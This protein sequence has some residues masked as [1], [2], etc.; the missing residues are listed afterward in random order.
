MEDTQSVSSAPQALH[1]GNM[2]LQATSFAAS[3]DQADK[4]CVQVD[5]EDLLGSSTTGSLTK[6]FTTVSLPISHPVFS[7]DAVEVLAPFSSRT[8][9]I[10]LRTLQSNDTITFFAHAFG[11]D[12]HAE[13]LEVIWQFKL[14]AQGIRSIAIDET[15]KA[16]ILTLDGTE[17]APRRIVGEYTGKEH[18]LGWKEEHFRKFFDEYICFSFMQ[19]EDCVKYH[20]P[21]NWVDLQMPKW[22]S[23]TEIS[24]VFQP[25]VSAL[26]RSL[27]EII[28]ATKESIQA[29]KTSQHGRI[30][31][32]EAGDGKLSRFI[33]S[34]SR[35]IGHHRNRS[36]KKGNL[37]LSSTKALRP[38]N[39]YSKQAWYHGRKGAH[40]RKDRDRYNQKHSVL[41][42]I[43]TQLTK[44]SQSPKSITSLRDTNALGAVI[45]KTVKPFNYISTQFQDRKPS[46]EKVP[47]AQP[48]RD[49]IAQKIEEQLLIPAQNEAILHI[50]RTVSPK[51]FDQ[52]RSG[53]LIDY[54][55]MSDGL[56]RQLGRL[57]SDSPYSTDPSPTDREQVSSFLDPEASSAQG[58]TPEMVLFTRIN[59]SK[60]P[61]ERQEELARITQR[62]VPS[63]AALPNSAC[64]G[65]QPKDLPVE[66][67]IMIWRYVEMHLPK[68]EDVDGMEIGAG[69]GMGGHG[70]TGEIREGKGAGG[71]ETLAGMNGGR[72]LVGEDDLEIDPDIDLDVDYDLEIE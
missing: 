24:A 1:N 58:L 61:A 21:A 3:V 65:L 31:A 6:R 63:L 56:Y 23:A 55:N 54:R 72:G 26:D 37:K 4:T 22:L 71:L 17:E 49:F 13:Q 34:Q 27:Q 32:N 14:F 39:I 8:G 15:A 68:E 28:S 62:T 20:I 43:N 36:S 53:R 18:Y 69:E 35:S 45:S 30:L 9:G 48:V 11:D 57:I 38:D 12:L 70:G 66:N 59:I 7:A 5:Q 42:P 46:N 47:L 19:T 60:L 29:K 33:G 40:H 51:A 2:S 50:I 10:P 67:Q 44:T 25:S 16:V 41:P 52:R 64:Y